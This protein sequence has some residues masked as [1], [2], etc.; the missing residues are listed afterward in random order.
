MTELQ[1]LYE[2]VTKAIKHCPTASCKKCPCRAN[3]LE[4]TF[5]KDNA[6]LIEL[7]HAEIERLKAEGKENK[8]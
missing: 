7:Q 3:D 4:C 6:K 5:F 8:Q 2:K 1:E